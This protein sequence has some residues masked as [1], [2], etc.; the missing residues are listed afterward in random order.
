LQ[1][2]NGT[3]DPYVVVAY[4]KFGKPLFSTRVVEKD[5]NPVWE[6]TTF[7]LVT[8]DEVRADEKRE[9]RS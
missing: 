6:Q 8:D 4:S 2:D 7:L 3:S 1:D 9:W 5:L